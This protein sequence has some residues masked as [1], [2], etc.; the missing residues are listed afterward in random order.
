MT[1]ES[2]YTNLKQTFLNRYQQLPASYK[3]LTQDTLTNHFQWTRQNISHQQQF[4]SN[5]PHPDDHTTQTTD[6]PG[7]KP[8]TML[9]LTILHHCCLAPLYFNNKTS[10]AHSFTISASEPLYDSSSVRIE[11]KMSS[12]GLRIDPF[13]RGDR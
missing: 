2:C 7:F 6:T 9:N 12:T 10:C 3:R 11:F 8:F 4:F 5:Y 1:P 13:P